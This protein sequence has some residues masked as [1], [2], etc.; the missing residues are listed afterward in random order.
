MQ[1]EAAPLEGV[2][3]DIWRRCQ[4]RLFAPA[5]RYYTP[6][7]SPTAS[8]HFTHR[9]LNEILPEHNEG[10]TVIPQLIG[11]DA[12]DFLWAAGELRAMGYRE[13][14]L[15]LGCPSG[16][17][18]AK[19]KGAGLLGE[20]ALLTRLLDGIF[21]RTPVAVSIKTRIGLQS[22]DEWEALLRLFERYPLCE[23]IVHARTRD[24]QYRG[25]PHIA[26]WELAE[27]TSSL[28]LCYNGDLFDRPSAESFASAHPQAR[29]AML[30]RGLIANPNLIGELRGGPALTREA[31]QIFHD[32][33]Y[34][35]CR[36][37]I[38][39]EKPLLLHMK[40]LWFYL[41]CCLDGADRPLKLLRK[42]RTAAEYES[43][44]RSLFTA[45]PVRPAAGFRPS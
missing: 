24:Q 13:V 9:E 20:P 10:L 32:E 2:T 29:S 33:L 39:Y 23:L 38:V 43:A 5:D 14:N 27:N 25:A 7:L 22:P 40:E 45:C 15:N 6:F 41:G 26:A 44:V 4:G 34:A 12:E 8:R 3:N 36:E 42:S 19:K 28:P 30:G 31:L 18:T 35:A 37:R 1:W 17:V 16:T 11:H 21:D